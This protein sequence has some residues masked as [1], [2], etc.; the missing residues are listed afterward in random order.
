MLD[1]ETVESD[2]N[3]VPVRTDYAPRTGR[4]ISIAAALLAAALLVAFFVVQHGQKRDENALKAATADHAAALRLV[5]IV[6]AKPASATHSLALPGETRAWY[7]STIYARVSGYVNTW[8]VDIGDRVKKG[9][10]LARIDTPE[11]D[12][13]LAA[14]RAQLTQSEAE[15]KVREADANFAKSTYE[16]WRESPKGV[17]SEQEREEK[18]AGYESGIARLNAA[19]AKVKLDQANVD[20]LMEWTRFKEVV[21]PYD[22]VIT[23]RRV[24]IG[25]LVTAGSTAN[26]TP[27]F[28]IAQSQEIRV[29]VDV[30]QSASLALTPGTAARITANEFT[31]RV[32]TGEVARTTEAI[33]PH[34][35]TLR[36]EVDLP[37]KDLTL[38]PGMYVEVNFVFD[39][40]EP[41]VQVPASAMLFR[42]GGPQVAV[43]D[44]E[45]KVRFRDVTIGRDNG[46]TV[47]LAS[48]IKPGDKIALNISSEIAEGQTVS[49]TEQDWRSAA[50]AAPPAPADPPLRVPPSH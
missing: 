39:G 26:T 20:R 5:D 4:K 8:L 1:G 10:V 33:D 40:K 6:I 18:K 50:A 48:G 13:Q 7:E 24:D 29:F 43:I 34:A 12:D 19:Q 32:F 30:P 45:N 37:N 14:A 27:L 42:A 21:A 23:S 49:P 44:S 9:Q 11:L 41:M 16:R 38:R 2:S 15:V 47:D 17:V 22:G 25:D 31:N 35:R 46:D 28:S 3:H 36:V